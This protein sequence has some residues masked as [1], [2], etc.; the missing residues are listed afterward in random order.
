MGRRRSAWARRLL[1]GPSV[2][3]SP[4]LLQVLGLGVV[5]VSLHC[6]GMCGPI[7]AGL[8]GSG[9]EGSRGPRVGRGAA[10]VLTYQAGRAAMYAILGALAGWIGHAAEAV[11]ADVA[12]IAGLVLAA[13][14]IVAGVLQGIGARRPKVGEGPPLSARIVRTILRAIA[15][16]WP[17]RLP[18]RLAAVGFAMGLLPCMLMFWVLSLSAS[19]AS[20][21]QGALLMLTLVAMTTP[22]LLIAGCGPLIATPGAQRIGRWL[23]PAGVVL[24]GVWLGL[25][26]VAANGWIEHQWLEFTAFDRQYFVMFW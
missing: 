8:A 5:W 14:L 13:V 25:V 19:T 1:K 17:E 22:V 20:A 11:V 21:S 4:Q 3:T 23:V 7:V 6:A 9:A 12:K 15:K 18:G 26:S 2:E 16:A 24:S 10:R